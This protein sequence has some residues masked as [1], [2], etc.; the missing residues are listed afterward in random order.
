MPSKNAFLKEILYSTGEASQ[1]L[2][3]T[4]RAL[5]VAHDIFKDDARVWIIDIIFIIE[6]NIVC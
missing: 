3:D 4:N 1:L 5:Q 2:D 6:V